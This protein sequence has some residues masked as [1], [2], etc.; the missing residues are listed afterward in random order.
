MSYVQKPSL[1]D[2]NIVS[3]ALHSRYTFLRNDDSEVCCLHVIAVYI[4]LLTSG[5]LEAVYLQSVAKC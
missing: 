1:G 4:D 2:C 5:E 3:K